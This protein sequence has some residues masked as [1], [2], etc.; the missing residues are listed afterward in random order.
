MDS[1]QLA[2]WKEKKEK[3]KK[4]AEKYANKEGR[5][6]INFWRTNPL[7]QWPGKESWARKKQRHIPDDFD[8]NVY[9][10]MLYP[11]AESD[12]FL[13]RLL[14]EKKNGSP[15]FAKN[16]PD[17]LRKKEVYN[18]WIGEKM[19]KE[20]DLVVLSNILLYKVENKI[21]WNRS[22]SLSLT[23]IENTYRYCAKWKKG[24]LLSPQYGHYSTI[25]YHVSRLKEQLPKWEIDTEFLLSALQAEWTKSRDTV[26]KSMIGSAIYRLNSS[27]SE[28]WD[29]TGFS[30]E[31]DF[32][33]FYANAGSVFPRPLNK[34]IASIPAYFMPY[35]CGG[36]NYFLVWEYSMLKKKRE[37]KT[38][39]LH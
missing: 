3:L 32:A 7:D 25:L 13:C 23:Y 15:Y 27:P 12:L 36:L 33:F 38:N 14:E 4:T 26:E 18:T 10:R 11:D 30:G 24:K 19:P 1:E 20:I 31:S 2:L 39:S 35:Q 22:D 5:N 37:F 16:L 21:V 34:I 17:S 8:D 9:L 29:P 6:T 28:S